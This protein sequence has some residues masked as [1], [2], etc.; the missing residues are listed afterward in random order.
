MIFFNKKKPMIFH[1]LASVFRIFRATNFIHF[2]EYHSFMCKK[3]HP[4][5]VFHP[6]TN[7]SMHMDVSQFRL[8][9]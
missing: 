8:Q 3:N 6:W 1:I 7:T 2:S 9:A 5:Q 4:I